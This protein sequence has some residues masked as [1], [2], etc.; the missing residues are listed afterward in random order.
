MSQRSIGLSN[1]TNLRSSVRPKKFPCKDSQMPLLIS[2]FT[3]PFFGIK[4]IEL[5]YLLNTS[6]TFIWSIALHLNCS[7]LKIGILI[8]GIPNDEVFLFCHV[9]LP[10]QHQLFNWHLT[11]NEYT[12]NWRLELWQITFYKEVKITRMM[13]HK[14]TWE[15]QNKAE[16]VVKQ[17]FYG[18]CSH[19]HPLHSPSI[20][21]AIVASFTWRAPKSLVEPTWGSSM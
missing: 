4:L 7:L 1:G 12:H 20:F 17:I 18:W 11:L 6:F 5:E 2:G 19:F 14:K 10:C 9:R 21:F 16:E 13:F 8:I 3:R 15:H